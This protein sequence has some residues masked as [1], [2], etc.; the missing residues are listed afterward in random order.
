MILCVRLCVDSSV[1]VGTYTYI[2]EL[3]HFCVY[4]FPFQ[5]A[6]LCDCVRACFSGCQ[7]HGGARL[8]SAASCSLCDVG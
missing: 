1:R 7:S 6:H 5:H 8:I 4:A 3:M 2:N